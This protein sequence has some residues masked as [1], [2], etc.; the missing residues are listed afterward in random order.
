MDTA[1]F[2]FFDVDETLIDMKSMF[3]FRRYYFLRRFGPVLG[4]LQEWRARRRLQDL[5]DCGCDRS[6]VNR[7]FF[8]EFAGHAP[9]QL[10]AAAKAWFAEVSSR[11][12]FYIRPALNALQRHIDHGVE[13]VFVSGSSVDILQPLAEALGVRHVL[14]N[15]LEVRNGRYSGELLSPQTIGAGKQAAVLAFLARC[16]SDAAVCYGYGDHISDL[17][18]LETV[19][20]PSVVARD[21]ELVRA[22]NQRG[23]PV[24]KP[25]AS[26]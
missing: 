2:A 3:S 6:E 11:D 13:P 24:L 22:A 7:A 5:L 14:A 21:P 18:L 16:G 20:H 15:R 10:A 17:P 25:S 1:R 4:R 8:R 12:G 23:W 26:F 9:E 19:G